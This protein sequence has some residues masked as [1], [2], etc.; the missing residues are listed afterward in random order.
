MQY[1]YEDKYCVAD[2]ALLLIAKELMKYSNG[3]Q[4]LATTVEQTGTIIN[5]YAELRTGVMR[6]DG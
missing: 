3:E 2:N 1:S 4:T 5:A 6:E